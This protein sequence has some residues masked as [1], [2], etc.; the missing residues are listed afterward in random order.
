LRS[1]EIELLLP[2]IV[3]RT[4][5]DAGPTA[6]LLGVMELL[7][8][9]A[10]RVLGA[11][12]SYFDPYRTEDDFVP[13]LA[14]WMDL[15]RYLIEAPDRRSRHLPFPTGTGRLREL[16]RA[17]AYLSQ[18]RGTANG[19]IR[20]LET[21]TGLSGFR[22]EENVDGATQRERPFHIV[23]HAPPDAEPYRALVDRIIE[24][25]KPAYVTHERIFDAA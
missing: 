22:V 1:A 6:A 24:L 3:R 23:V 11:L 5:R 9:P 20:F 8:L 18:W 19:L 4:V 14:W 13:F 17:A 12:D 7:H 21:A 2:E 25:E 16:V 10:D 15:G